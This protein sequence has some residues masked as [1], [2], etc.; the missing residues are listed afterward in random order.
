MMLTRRGAARGFALSPILSPILAA[1]PARAESSTAP[2]VI[3]YCDAPLRAALVDAGRAFTDR[4]GARVNV[5]C[6]APWMMLAQIEHVSQNDILISGAAAL[7]EAATRKLIRAETRLPL[8]RNGLV[9]A[10]RIGGASTPRT[11]AEAIR[12]LIGVG[13]LAITDSTSLATIDAAGALARIG[14]S[15]PYG[16]RTLGGADEADVA[17]L[18]SSGAALLGLLHVT[19]ARADPRLTEAAVLPGGASIG[20]EAAVSVIS[21]SPNAGRFMD[22]LRSNEARAR[23]ASAG[24]S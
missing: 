15:A 24:L 17:F 2:N 22:F 13:P 16:F 7:D 1:G 8:G 11:G 4:T 3:V 21:R 10:A 9:L 12:A 20:Y 18:V 14:V 19:T 23:L 5:F 6:A